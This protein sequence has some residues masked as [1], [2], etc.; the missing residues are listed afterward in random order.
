MFLTFLI[1]FIISF[2]LAGLSFKGAEIVA[3]KSKG[4]GYVLGFT[5]IYFIF[6]PSEIVYFGASIWPKS[7]AYIINGYLLTFA[8]LFPGAMFGILTHDKENPG[9]TK[10]LRIFLC[11]IFVFIVYVS[12]LDQ[13]ILLAAGQK[14]A[15]LN[16]K[17]IDGVVRQSTGYSCYPSSTATVLKMWGIDVTEGDVAINSGT[18]FRGTNSF[19]IMEAVETLGENI[20]LQAWTTTATLDEIKAINLP[21]VLSVKWGMIN[22]ASALIGIETNKIIMGEP[23]QGR[24]VISESELF[25]SYAW[26]GTTLFIFNTDVT[27]LDGSESP[28]TL[29]PVFNELRNLGLVKSDHIS[30]NTFQDAIKKLQEKYKLN[31]TGYADKK[32]R[33]VLSS[34]ANF[35]NGPRLIQ[36]NPIS[37]E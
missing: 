32:T 17:T 36:E 13:I 14:I 3:K 2:L 12:L 8:F 37:P 15:N 24:R 5:G 19:G 9:R 35:N 18:T 21:C 23:M 1:K 29:E 10:R 28:E 6:F 26:E 7:I 34:R 31:V 4:W 27:E 25:G 33:L 20:N 30:Q 11:I 16:G 22:H